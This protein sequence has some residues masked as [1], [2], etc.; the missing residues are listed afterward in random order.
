V[1]TLIAGELAGERSHTRV[2]LPSALAAAFLA[3]LVVWFVS[4]A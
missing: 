4:S 2:L 1:A 3:T